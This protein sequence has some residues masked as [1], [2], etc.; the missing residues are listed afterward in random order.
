MY[1]LAIVGVILSVL[2]MAISSGLGVS[3]TLVMYF[4]IPS[5]ILLIILCIPML[6]AAGLLRDFNNAFAIALSK[7]KIASITEIKRAIE[8]VE[9]TM[10]SLMYGSIFTF[11]FSL[12]IILRCVDSLQLLAPNFSVAILTFIYA[13]GFNMLLLPIKAKLNIKMTEYMQE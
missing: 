10:K 11:L 12:I 5:V 4:D 13:I 6:L 7:K 2:V 8:A 1:I 3:T 9:L